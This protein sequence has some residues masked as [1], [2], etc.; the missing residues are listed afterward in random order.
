MAV[1]ERNKGKLLRISAAAEAAG[2][3]KR[4]VEY[5]VMLG[6]IKPIR[7][8]GLS[9]RY[10]DEKLV[11]RIRLI[12]RLNDSGYTLRDIRQTYLRRGR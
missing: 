6:L 9:G 11:R 5:Y 1:D 12:K 7:P 10:F 2:I 3:S 8:P 4:T